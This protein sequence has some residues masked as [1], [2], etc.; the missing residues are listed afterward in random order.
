MKKTSPR[1]LLIS[2]IENIPI[3]VF[4][5]DMNSRYLGCNTLFARDAGLS[6]PADLLGKDDEQMSWHDQAELYRADDKRVM[7]SGLP[8]LNYV[9]PQTTPDGQT[10]WLRTSKV[11]L[12]DAEGKIFGMLGTYDDITEHKLGEMALQRALRAQR[13]LSASNS[14]LIHATQEDKILQDMCRAVIEQGEYRL[15]WF[16]YVEHDEAK[17]VRPAA[18][19]GYEAGYL[20]KLNITWAD[21]ESGRGP[22]GTAVRSGKPQVSRAIQ[23]D[24]NMTHWRE[25]AL[26]RGYASIIALPVKT[27]VGAML[28]VFTI[29]AHESDAF[30]ETEIALLSEMASDL[31]FGIETLR[32]RLRASYHELQVNALTNH[33]PDAILILD[34]A[35][36]IEFANPAAERLFGQSAKQLLGSPFGWSTGPDEATEIEIFPWGDLNSGTPR[37]AELRLIDIGSTEGAKTLVFLHDITEK[38]RAE[39]LTLRMGRM[40][41]NSWDEIYVFAMD[42]LTFI[43]VSVGGMKN[44]GYSLEEL[45]QMTPLD[46][47]PGFTR[48]QFDA[49]VAP[50]RNGDEQEVKFEAEQRRKDGSTYPVDVRLQLS[51]EEQPPVF[52]ANT[53][54][55][56]ERKNY[57]TELEHKA[58][59]DPLTDLPNRALLQDRLG[60]A[61]KI[62]R[63]ESASL[64]V[65]SM[66]LLH[67]S[68]IN[69]LMGYQHGDRVLQEISSRLLKT[70]R[71][72]DTV[73]RLSDGVFAILLAGATQESAQLVA[74]KIMKTLELPV[75]IDG[76]SLE[77]EAAFGLVLYPD[78]GEDTS[79]LLQRSDIAMRLAK[80]DGVGIL[81]YSDE[82]DPFSMQRLRLHG[83]LR[84]AISERS[85]MVYYQPQV[86]IKTGRIMGVEALSRWPHPDEGMISPADFIPMIEQSGLI[87]PFTLWV[88]EEAIIL[89]QRWAA[90]GIDLNIAVNISARN[91]LDPNLTETIARLLETHQVSAKNLSLEIT[92]SAIMSR[93]EQALKVLGQLHEIGL[94]LSIDDF[95]TGF[96]SLAYLKKLPVDE[97]KID[98]SFVFGLTDNDDDAVIVRSTIEL[99]H[100]LG[101]KTVA[102]GIENKE[103]LDMLAS[104]NCDIAQGFYLSRPVPLA[105]LQQF[106]R[107]SPWGLE[108]YVGNP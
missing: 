74:Q 62:A 19:A 84:K 56:S 45:R 26:K 43:E 69:D 96:S 5:K 9:E 100:N 38:R 2:I 83:Q 95:G 34:A 94:K 50:L 21:T 103:T 46:I 107:D 51:S 3:R 72:S 39:K 18:S 13:A 68:E 101:L 17:S 16:G 98:Q 70:C 54:D 76:F 64:A 79:T 85:L 29:Y 22:T 57:I 41:K 47:K 78:H 25:E 106:L 42:T 88:L 81:I 77:I 1:D 97:I 20:E 44:L 27:A 108:S 73:A 35:R 32:H 67:L 86:D 7:E 66:D 11:P 61:L 59:Y 10:I 63:R 92:E 75:D 30:D 4:W 80:H 23:T 87:L 14:I 15:A 28:G 55:I 52:I 58:L 71:E 99:A 90:D 102:E 91:L 93:P 53:Q 36:H 31:A 65:L 12:Q 48:T 105:E 60:L 37:L 8:E 49:L 82:D 24:P 33:N 104:L 89:L 6:S 40:L